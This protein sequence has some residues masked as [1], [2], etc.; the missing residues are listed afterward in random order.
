M[1]KGYKTLAKSI[2]KRK[3]PMQ[4]ESRTEKIKQFISQLFLNK[5]ITAIGAGLIVGTVFGFTALHFLTNDISEQVMHEEQ[6]NGQRVN[7]TTSTADERAPLSITF[8]TVYVIQVGL[9]HERENARLKQDQL[10]R[11]NI[12]TFIWQRNDEYFLLHGIFST[13]LKAQEANGTLQDDAI[14]SFVKEWVISEAN[15]HVTDVEAN[16]IEQ[17]VQLWKKSFEQFELAGQ[18]SVQTWK[19]LQEEA[20]ESEMIT[21]IQLQLNSLLS[22]LQ[23][24]N[25]DDVTLLQMLQLLEK[26]IKK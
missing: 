10:K 1:K 9:F 8:P 2:K 5:F 15:K 17:Y 16:F 7:S 6:A 26:M 20:V 3:H 22:D 18:V 13:Q 25:S 11:R 12:N 23:E 24:E 21:E 4:S 14:Q 19:P